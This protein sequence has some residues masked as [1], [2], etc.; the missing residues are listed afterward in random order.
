MADITGYDEWKLADGLN[1]DNRKIVGECA[2]CLD[3]IYEG[4]EVWRGIS[5]EYDVCSLGCLVQFTSKYDVDIDEFD[6][7][8]AKGAE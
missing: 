5:G 8:E 7:N 2:N 4:S 6:K 3:E 1:V